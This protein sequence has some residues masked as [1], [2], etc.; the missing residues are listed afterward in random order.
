[1]TESQTVLTSFDILINQ[2]VGNKDGSTCMG[3]RPKNCLSF[4]L[5]MSRAEWKRDIWENEKNLMPGRQYGTESTIRP[6]AQLGTWEEEEEEEEG[7]TYPAGQGIYISMHG[8]QNLLDYGLLLIP[9]TVGETTFSPE[10]GP[11]R[12][13]ELLLLLK[14]RTRSINTH[15]SKR[16]FISSQKQ[17]KRMFLYLTTR[18]GH[19]G[20]EEER[21]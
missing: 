17:Q 3:L 6:C 12:K 19:M 4:S 5:N 15:R 20:M 7:G 21:F 10:L 8:L 11:R 16:R 18:Q 9:G 1:M 2:L 14:L 13:K